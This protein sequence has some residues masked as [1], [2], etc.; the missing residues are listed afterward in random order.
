MMDASLVDRL[1]ALPTLQDIP[2]H[3]LE[4]LVD[5]GEVVTFPVGDKPTRTGGSVHH[6][7]II[8]SGVLSIRIDRGAG[9]RRVMGWRAGSV[10]GKLPYSRMNINQGETYVEEPVEALQVPSSVFPEMIQRCPELTTHCVHVMVDRARGFRASDLQDEKMVSLGKLAAGLAHELNNPASATLRGAKLLLDGLSETD[11][12]VEALVAAS[13]DTDL[14][15]V[16]ESVR[17]T[18]RVDPAERSLSPFEQAD[19]EDAL[20]DW[21][22]RHGCDAALADPLAETAVDPG[23]LDALAQATEGDALRAAVRWIA[24]GCQTQWLARDIEKA[25]TQIHELVSSVKRFTYMDNLSAPD[26]VDVAVGLRDTARV[27]ASKAKD[28]HVTLAIDVEPDLPRAHASGAELNQVWS[29]L[30]DNAIDA[31]SEE[32]RVDITARTTHD[33]VEVSVIDDGPGIAADVLPWIFDPFYT[34]KPP[35]HGTGLGLDI[36]RRL[37]RRHHGDITVD[38]RPGRTEFK[39]ALRAT[40]P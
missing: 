19:R 26:S 11:A 17:N 15:S 39:V 10:T 25:A 1:A 3:E 38:S 4:W 40:S 36:A 5:H 37:V 29:N 7:W 8:L 28:K 2:R 27:Y 9:P 32:G 35:G 6:L 31:V 24:S 22:S 13:V 34:T 12:I 23:S 16:I 18:C 33:R 30:L 14:L 20:S 21:L